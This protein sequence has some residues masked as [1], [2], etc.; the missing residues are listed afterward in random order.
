VYGLLDSRWQVLRLPVCNVGDSSAS[1]NCFC[2]SSELE[3]KLCQLSFHTEELPDDARQ[4]RIREEARR[5]WKHAKAVSRTV[6]K[7]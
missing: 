7:V 2:I 1:Q 6:P 3:T 5:S 4:L